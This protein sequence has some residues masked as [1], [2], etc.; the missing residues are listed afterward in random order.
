MV[1]EATSSIVNEKM[2]PLQV[3]GEGKDTLK[4]MRRKRLQPHLLSQVGA[5][6]AAESDF[7]L[8]SDFSHSQDEE[9]VL[10]QPSQKNEEVLDAVASISDEEGTSK[11]IRKTK[12]I[13]QGLVLRDTIEAGVSDFAFASTNFA[14]LYDFS[15]SQDA[16]TMLEQPSLNN[17]RTFEAVTSRRPSLQVSGDEESTSAR[18]Q[19]RTARRQVLDPGDTMNFRCNVYGKSFNQRGTLMTHM[20][21]HFGEK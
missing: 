17:G 3:S 8:A 21:T 6:L 7:A 12:P 14:L 10:E 20:P 11:R 2:F 16:E 15:Y 5:S 9:A 18:K 1:D 4:S 13:R 19:R